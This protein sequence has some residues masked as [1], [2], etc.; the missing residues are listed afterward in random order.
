MLLLLSSS[1]QCRLLIALQEGK[2]RPANKENK[3]GKRSTR[4][5]NPADDFQ[6]TSPSMETV[7]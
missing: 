1:N 7:S 2:H 5:A 6:S 3:S 4:H